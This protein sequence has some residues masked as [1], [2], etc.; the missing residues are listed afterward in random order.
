M[1]LFD[2][3]KEK[4]EKE[5][6]AKFHEECG[7]WE[8][9]TRL[10]LELG[11]KDRA[12]SCLEKLEIQG[13]IKEA[14]DIWLEL[15][16]K[17]RAY[18]CVEK[19][20]SRGQW[21]KA[22][23]IWLEI[24]DKSRAYKCAEKMDYYDQI[25]FWEGQGEILKS[26]D[27]RFK[28]LGF[29]DQ[30][31]MKKLLSNGMYKEALEYAIHSNNIYESFQFYSENILKAAAIDRG[32]SREVFEK[33]IQDVEELYKIIGRLDLFYCE[34]LPKIG[35]EDEAV[36]KVEAKEKRT[37]RENVLLAK[38]YERKNEYVKAE[39]YYREDSENSDELFAFLLRR[40]RVEEA[41]EMFSKSIGHVS[42]FVNNTLG[43]YLRKSYEQGKN[44]EYYLDYLDLC[45]K[46]EE[47]A[48][49]L[50]RLGR[51]NE[52]AQVFLK[53]GKIKEAASILAQ[54]GRIDE[55]VNLCIDNNFPDQA[56]NLLLS[57]GRDLDAAT[58]LEKFGLIEKALEVYKNAKR[59]DKVII[60]LE[61]LQRVNELV[62]LYLDLNQPEKAA[63]LLVCNGRLSEAAKIYEDAGCFEKAADLLLRIDN[64]EEP[65]NNVTNQPDK[66]EDVKANLD[67]KCPNCGKPIQVNF[68]IC[69]YCGYS[70]TK[71]SK[72]CPSC[73]NELELD[74]KICPYCGKNFKGISEVVDSFSEIPER[75]D[76]DKKRIIKEF[77]SVLKLKLSKEIEKEYMKRNINNQ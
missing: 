59:Y 72:K 40:D 46:Y 16:N 50:L 28:K 13:Q 12:Y 52:T 51:K 18:T 25:E 36:R 63:E 54:I 23:Y 69:P 26:I 21:K 6:L 35:L 11:D 68:T 56:A 38:Y 74:W 41:M 42:Q 43:N 20:E 15:G 31:S 66:I 73:G 67:L 3:Y 7:S 27:I 8:A 76:E 14:L 71:K 37:P 32:L 2:S 33:L 34:L 64:S 10:W 57:H 24:G 58:V 75:E 77:V 48:N 30:E 49:V 29:L 4:K 53:A 70:L 45:G 39:N 19:L 60:I 44:V 9:A 5:G 61:K 55:A 62:D 47:K 17:D 65:R 22:A 1:G